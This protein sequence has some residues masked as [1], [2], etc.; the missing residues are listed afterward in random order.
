[1]SSCGDGGLD[2]EGVRV[3]IVSLWMEI[4]V[5]CLMMGVPRVKGIRTGS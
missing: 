4:V 3:R 2:G 5:A 1:M